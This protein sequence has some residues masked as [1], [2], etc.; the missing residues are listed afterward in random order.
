MKINSS[1][2]SVYFCAIG[3]V[4]LHLNAFALRNRNIEEAC[5]QIKI[6]A[7]KSQEDV[8]TFKYYSGLP[9]PIYHTFYRDENSNYYSSLEDKLNKKR[10]MTPRGDISLTPLKEIS[11]EEYQKFFTTCGIIADSEMLEFGF[12][13]AESSFDPVTLA[14]ELENSEWFDTSYPLFIA[15]SPGAMN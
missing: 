15:N 7:A 9:K 8:V 13:L 10:S 6:T 14:K 11:L 4:A 12:Y 1:L 5:R 2:K 3:L